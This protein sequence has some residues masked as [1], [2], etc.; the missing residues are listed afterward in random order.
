MDLGLKDK[1]IIVSGG[2]SG[3]GKGIV[4]ALIAEGSIPCIFDIN[5]GATEEFVSEIQAK[6]NRIHYVIADLTDNTACKN[7]IYEVVESAG[8]IYGVINNAGVNDGVS[9][10]NGSEESF[11]SSLNKNVAHYYSLAHFALPFLKVT[12]GKIINIVSKTYTTGQGGT[13]GYAAA[14]GIRASITQDW[15]LELS[16]YEIKVN[17]VVVAECWTPQYE[18]W[19]NQKPNPRMELNKIKSR[20]PLGKRMTTVEEIADMVLFILSDKSTFCTGQTI[21]V[22]GGYI[23]LDRAKP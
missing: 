14:N 19:I 11:Q 4:R 17:A 21:H 3:I 2:A 7:A 10:E 18:F 23:H 5:Q 15:A 9:L 16:K 13:S 8:N 22:D 6:G 12:K 1:V 20:I